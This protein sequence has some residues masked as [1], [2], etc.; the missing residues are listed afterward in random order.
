MNMKISGSENVSRK[1]G[2]SFIFLQYLVIVSQRTNLLEGELSHSPYPTLPWR[3]CHSTRPEKKVMHWFDW[4]RFAKDRYIFR[5]HVLHGSRYLHFRLLLAPL[6]THPQ[7][8]QNSVFILQSSVFNFFSVG[9]RKSESERQRNRL[10]PFLTYRNPQCFSTLESP[11]TF[12]ISLC[13]TVETIFSTC[14][15]TVVGCAPPKNVCTFWCFT[16]TLGV[17]SPESKPWK[18]CDELGNNGRIRG[19]RHRYVY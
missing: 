1:G 8:C 14:S 4:S 5:W 19:V 7:A 12:E 16:Y 10:H 13:S 6:G 2:Y 3:D 17:F 11:P 18:G 9:P 15:I